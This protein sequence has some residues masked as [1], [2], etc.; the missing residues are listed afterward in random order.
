M[1]IVTMVLGESGTGKSASLRN[2]GPAN[3]LLIQAVRKPL[4]FKSPE[5]KRFDNE[6]CR[7]GNIFH[8][9][10]AGQ[11]ITLMRKTKRKIIVL[12]DFQYVMANEFMRRTNE[13]GFDKFTEIGKNAWDIIN[14]AA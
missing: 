11:I 5:W 2:L 4:P 13:K 9:D 3:A 14:A 8:T 12:D 7:T 6:T 10:H 1:S